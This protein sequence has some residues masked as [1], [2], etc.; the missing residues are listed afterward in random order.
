V[1]SAESQAY[2]ELLKN[3]YKA[4]IKVAKPVAG[5]NLLPVAE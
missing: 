3:R 5:G 4:Q 1:A 2:Y